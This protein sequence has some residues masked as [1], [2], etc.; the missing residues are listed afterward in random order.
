M[1]LFSSSSCRAWPRVGVRGD[2][3]ITVRVLVEHPLLKFEVVFQ[4]RKPS[5]DLKLRSVSAQ[6]DDGVRDRD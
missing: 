5:I 4:S 1:D 2:I 3:Q 6:V